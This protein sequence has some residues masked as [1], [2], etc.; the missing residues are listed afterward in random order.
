MLKFF[1]NFEVIYS[2]IRFAEGDVLIFL[3]ILLVALVLFTAVVLYFFSIAFVK[4]NM[5]NVDDVEAEIN[6]PLWKYKDEI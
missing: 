2:S 5:G 4:H 6:K 1:Y 3:I